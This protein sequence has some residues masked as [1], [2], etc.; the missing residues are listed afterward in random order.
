MNSR[1]DLNNEYALYF[2]EN[3]IS[4]EVMSLIPSSIARQYNLFP[5]KLE[6]ENHISLWKIRIIL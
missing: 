3:V 2:Q 4:E 5:F 1:L 6:D